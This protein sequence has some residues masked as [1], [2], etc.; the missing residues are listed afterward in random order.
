[1]QNPQSGLADIDALEAEAFRAAQSGREQDALRLWGR[2]LELNPTHGRTLAVLGQQAFR[3]GDMQSARNAFQRLADSDGSDPQQWIHLALACRGANDEQA[4]ESAL[5][6]A[7]SLDPSDLVG[8]I[9]RANLLERQGKTHE[10][11]RAYGAVAKVSPPL[12]RLRPELRPAVS[13]ALA[14]V[15]K[16]NA[17]LAAFMDRYLEPHFKE[18]GGEDLRRFRDSLDIMV[19]RKKRFDSQSAIYH[20][21]RL[22]PIEFFDRADFPWLDPIEAATDEI[23]T[24]FLDVLK[25]E[26]GFTPYI[27]YPPDVPHNQWAELNNSPRWSAFHLYKLGKL[28]EENAAKCPRTMKALEGAPQPDQPGR[29][30]A[31]MFSLLKPKTRIPPHN[32][33]TNVR[34]VTHLP[35]IIPEECGFR[36]G[37]DTRQWIPGKAWVFDDTIDHEAWNNSEKLRVV[38]IFDVWHPHLTSAERAMV[39]ALTAGVNE[40]SGD[41]GAAELL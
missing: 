38:L 5:K 27:S 9:L 15:Q 19:G 2:I 20:Y 14:H 7:L 4:E 8:L 10:A 36:V 18:F 41:A 40:F 31:A 39:T 24:E 28:V 16:Y 23:R 3:K 37:N 30:P 33:V 6:R 35:L 17:E 1:M 32:G 25:A 13:Q 29:T 34:L 26:E 22:A 12:E 11:A 21:P